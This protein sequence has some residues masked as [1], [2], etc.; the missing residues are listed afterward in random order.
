MAADVRAVREK[1]QRYLTDFLGTIQIDR[2]GDFTFRHGS[3]RV[4]VSVAEFGPDKTVVRITAPTNSEVTPTPD[5]YHYVATENK[6]VF[7]SMVAVESQGKA[8]VLFKHSLLGDTLDPDE[9]LLAVGLVAGTADEIDNEIKSR[10][11][12]R[13]FHED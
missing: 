3:A 7:G 11:G 8:G 6:Y 4:F 12:G 13:V 5:F 9:L 1:V 10:F 2:D